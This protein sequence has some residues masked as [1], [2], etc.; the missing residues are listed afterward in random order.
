MELPFGTFAGPKIDQGAN[1]G[2]WAETVWM[3]SVWV[4]DPRT[5]WEPVDGETAILSVP[6]DRGEQS[7]VIRFDPDTGLVSHM[8]SMRYKGE[9]AEKKTLWLN[10]AYR[11]EELD[12]RLTLTQA[13]LTWL[14][15]GSPWAVFN[16]DGIVYNSDVSEYIRA[17]G[18]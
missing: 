18:L 8:E 7:F 16:L 14:D 9:E 17:T 13:A 4:T 10:I 11:W 5:R 3:P 12:G 6:F 2:L 15:E 1:L